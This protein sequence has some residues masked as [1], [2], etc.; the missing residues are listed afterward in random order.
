MRGSLFIT[1]DAAADGLLNT[2]PDALIIGMLLDQQVPMEVAF[3]GP[4]L[5]L[6]RLGHMDPTRIAAMDVEEFVAVCCERPAVHRFPAAMG[7][8]IHALCGE[9][10][11]RFGG[12]ADGLWADVDHADELSG[13]LRSL[14]GFGEEKTMIFVALLAKRM[15]I[16]PSGWRVAAGV[17]GDDTPRSVADST[18][19]DTLAVVR[20]WKRAQKAKRLDKQDRP[21][22][23]RP[24]K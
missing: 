2:N 14:P 23:P 12:A 15:G 5:L 21:F 6:D 8:R 3:R 24:S 10:T 9:L 19:P 1:G 18:S 13:R 4:H 16:T 17:F 22:P 11:V 7:R 20:E